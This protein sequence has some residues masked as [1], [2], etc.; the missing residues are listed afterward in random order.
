MD[1]WIIALVGD[2][3]VGKTALAVA[4]SL[5]T[6]VG[7]P[8]TGPDP[9]FRKQ[10]ILDNRM[11]FVEVLDPAG[12][13]VAESLQNQFLREAE[14]FILVYSI[15]ARSSFD[16]IEEFH[17]AAV[18]VK[19]ANSVFMLVGNKCDKKLEREVSR[20]DGIAL[21]RQLG[22]EFMETSAKTAENVERTF[23]SIVR[24]LRQ[25]KEPESSATQNNSGK[26]KKNCIIL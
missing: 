26:K 14:G 23:T 19:G 15:T 10:F 22:C 1:Q 21:A 4:F 8:E 3:G 12:G 24:V 5:N 20:D 25:M 7:M 16:R 18:R 13:Q 6:H 17:Q 9:V 2:G 11:C